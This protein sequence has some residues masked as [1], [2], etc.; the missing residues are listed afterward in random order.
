MPRRPPSKRLSES[1]HDFSST[2]EDEEE[3]DPLSTDDPQQLERT[4]SLKSVSSCVGAEYEGE[5]V[6]PPQMEIQTLA[7]VIELTSSFTTVSDDLSVDDVTVIFQPAAPVVDLTADDEDDA[8]SHFSDGSKSMGSCSISSMDDEENQLSD[9][10]TYS[11]LDCLDDEATVDAI[12]EVPEELSTSFIGKDPKFKMELS[13]IYEEHGNVSAES[14][15]G[16]NTPCDKKPDVDAIISAG[17]GLTAADEKPKIPLAADFVVKSEPVSECSDLSAEYVT[18]ASGLEEAGS[19]PSTEVSPSTFTRSLE[20]VYEAVAGDDELLPVTDDYSVNES[21]TDSALGAADLTFVTESADAIGSSYSV[22]VAVKK[23]LLFFAHVLNLVSTLENQYQ[24]LDTNPSSDSKPTSANSN[25]DLSTDTHSSAAL[26]QQNPNSEGH[27]ISD[28]SLISCIADSD[29]FP[30][31]KPVPAIKKCFELSHS[32]SNIQIEDVETNTCCSEIEEENGGDSDVASDALVSEPLSADYYEEILNSLPGDT[33]DRSWSEEEKGLYC[34]NLLADTSDLCQFEEDDKLTYVPLSEDGSHHSAPEDDGLVEDA[35]SS[36]AYEEKLECCVDADKVASYYTIC[37]KVI[38]CGQ[39]DLP[40]EEVVLDPP[41]LA[42]E[43]SHQ[44]TYGFSLDVLNVGASQFSHYENSSVIVGEKSVDSS[45]YHHD[46]YTVS[47]TSYVEEPELSFPSHH[48]SCEESDVAPDSSDYFDTVEDASS[49]Q[50][51]TGSVAEQVMEQRAQESSDCFDSVEE[52]VSLVYTRTTNPKSENADSHLIPN[53]LESASTE[54]DDQNEDQLL[55]ESDDSFD[56]VK[57][58]ASLTSIHV[59]V[60]ENENADCPVPSDSDVAS[61]ANEGFGS[62]QLIQETHNWEDNFNKCMSVISYSA[63]NIGNDDTSLVPSDL[64]VTAENTD[65]VEIQL[66]RESADCSRTVEESISPPPL[67]AADVSYDDFICGVKLIESLVEDSQSNVPQPDETDADPR[68]PF[69]PISAVEITDQVVVEESVDAS[70]IDVHFTPGSS[71]FEQVYIEG[72]IISASTENEVRALENPNIIAQTLQANADAICL[73]FQNLNVTDILNSKCSS[74][75]PTAEENKLVDQNEA[76]GA[77]SPKIINLESVFEDDLSD[78]EGDGNGSDILPQDPQT[79]DPMAE[80]DPADV[81]LRFHLDADSAD[82]S[83]ADA[84]V[85]GEL[86]VDP[87]KILADCINW[88]FSID[89]DI[90][91][92]VECV[93]YG[94]DPELHGP[95]ID[96]EIV[97]ASQNASGN[98]AQE[99]YYKLPSTSNVECIPYEVVTA[100]EVDEAKA[101]APELFEVVGRVL[102]D[103]ANCSFTSSDS[104]IEYDVNSNQITTDGSPYVTAPQQQTSSIN[105]GAPTNGKSK[106]Y[107]RSSSSSS[108]PDTVHIEGRCSRQGSGHNSANWCQ[109]GD[110]IGELSLKLRLKVEWD[111]QRMTYAERS[112]SDSSGDGPTKQSSFDDDSLNSSGSA[113]V[114]AGADDGAKEAPNGRMLHSKLL[115]EFKHNYPKFIQYSYFSPKVRPRRSPRQAPQ[116]A[117][118]TRVRKFG[119]ASKAHNGSPPKNACH[120][121]D[122]ATIRSANCAT[123]QSVDSAKIRAV[124]HREESPSGQFLRFDDVSPGD[125]P[126]FAPTEAASKSSL[127]L[128][129]RIEALSFKTSTPKGQQADD[130]AA[131]STCAQPPAMVS[132]L[133]EFEMWES[134]LESN[135]EG[136]TH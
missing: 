61:V 86:A 59:A 46:T 89:K 121:A 88:L 126:S 34:D 17:L 26:V 119:E 93:E 28:S 105:T 27:T 51:V 130:S 110:S 112:S 47:N 82:L 133:Q 131:G 92:N 70:D 99:P 76:G 124:V 98:E 64:P 44:D 63:Y 75:E 2:T 94:D 23:F 10:N 37:P 49:L 96:L 29:E 116:T 33:S 11:C 7:E 87:I 31:A 84:P 20:T 38:D 21:V 101:A 55:Q 111:S 78:G 103:A 16:A 117:P 6:R 128:D 67:L 100:P 56:P 83:D 109:S 62:E 4:S 8:R 41:A 115:V 104:K 30:A 25:T 113:G 134:L 123:V 125:W 129:P 127:L 122:A 58:N 32:T 14:A 45:T 95:Q 60:A 132:S 15:D 73:S 85:V 43:A 52:S 42:S 90:V 97:E 13:V 50:V 102:C 72:S 54:S 136:V 106:Q 68:T 36:L 53:D 118:T 79:S 1:P 18:F 39:D 114:A 57:E 81:S 66:A 12:P 71:Y 24:P 5:E 135:P 107:R 48:S 108:S 74:I 120:S 9:S 35:L 65:P 3:E 19:W 22:S 91:E 40:S 80:D 77:E 69:T